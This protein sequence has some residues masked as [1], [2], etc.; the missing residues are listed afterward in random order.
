MALHRVRS[1]WMATR[2]ARISGMRG[3]LP[4][5]ARRQE[6]HAPAGVGARTRGRGATPTARPSRWR[7]KLARIA[8]A[9]WRH[10]RSFDGDHALQLA[11]A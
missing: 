1:Q 6:A 7:N 11:A 9:V 8:W 2:T 5:P 10:E 4:D 3:M